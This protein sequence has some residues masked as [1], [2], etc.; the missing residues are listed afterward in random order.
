STVNDMSI[1]L[2][3]ALARGMH[4]D[5]RLLS[6]D[7]WTTMWSPQ[8]T[9][10][11]NLDYGLGWMV[12]A[13][14]N[15]IFITHDGSIDGYGAHVGLF[16]D[17]DL[18]YVVLFNVPMIPFSA[19]IPSLVRDS[20]LG[21]PSVDDDAGDTVDVDG[22]FDAYL[23][24]YRPFIPNMK[25]KVITAL[26]QNG[27]L[28]IDVP[29]QTVYELDPPDDNGLWA[30]HGGLPISVSFDR[31]EAGEIVE[32]NLHQ[33]GMLFEMPRIGRSIPIEIPL[34]ELV[35]FLGTYA[36]EAGN[37]TFEVVIQNNRLAIDVP[38]ELTYE[39]HVPD[40][41]GWRI[42]RANASLSAHF[43]QDD[44]GTLRSFTLRGPRG[45]TLFVRT[46]VADDMPNVS[47]LM[48]PRARV[49][50]KLASF[51]PY[52]MTGVVRFI[53]SGIDGDV[54]R[55]VDEPSKLREDLNLQPFGWIHKGFTS[56]SGI[57][58][59]SMASPEPIAGRR[60]QQAMLGHPHTLLGDWREAF[61][62]IVVTAVESVDGA[63]QVTCR[64]S[65]AGVPDMYV[66]IDRITGDLIAM[67]MTV[68]EPGAPE[69]TISMEF[70][71]HRD[72]DGIRM[73]FSYAMT[74]EAI[75]RIE[76][77]FDTLERLDHVDDDVFT[78][79]ADP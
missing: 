62:A 29:G 56:E 41:D 74:H 7:A 66:T 46:A 2:R 58:S 11:E 51:G 15:E 28:A 1:W 35:P 73:P 47:D 10:T 71:D 9:I 60:L 27:R 65:K 4:G 26:V 45:E 48:E 44:D 34:E 37:P 5:E 12:S 17:D 68:I 32:M 38:N 77:S 52:R 57:E 64:L 42:A 76:A 75:G 69:M 36:P 49:T 72:V 67:T 59:T 14:G 30:F 70:G 54:I 23:G 20:V 22:A 8:M 16:P 61:D 63:E 55:I 25:G 13:A 24:E 50:E 40:D 6:N 79:K 21:D 43:D 53:H 78:L 3:F 19:V 18:G 31:N 39:L 33:A